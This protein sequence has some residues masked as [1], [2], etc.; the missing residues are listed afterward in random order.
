MLLTGVV[1]AIIGPVI[2]VLDSVLF[3]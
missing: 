3:A 1:W 2:E